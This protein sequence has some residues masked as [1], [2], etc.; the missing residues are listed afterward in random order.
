MFVGIDLGTTNSAVAYIDPREAEG[1]DFPPI[2][3][4][5]IP[6]HVDEERIEARRLL[7]SFLYL[8]E[9]RY[10]GAYAREQAALTP[11]RVVSSAKSWLSNADVDREAKILPWDARDTERSVSPVEASMEYIAHMR[12]A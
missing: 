11:T 7:P 2:R 10:I 12:R 1:A 3:L 8:G 4:L 9:K 6:Q 5:D